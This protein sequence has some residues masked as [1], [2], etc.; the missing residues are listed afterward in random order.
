MI[1]VFFV[2]ATLGVFAISVLLR[3]LLVPVLLRELLVPVL[4]LFLIGYVMMW[5]NGAPE[6]TGKPGMTPPALI[7]LNP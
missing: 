3:E 2:V 1:F 5:V 4:L 7:Q 6:R